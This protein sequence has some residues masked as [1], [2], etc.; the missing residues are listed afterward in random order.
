MK[1]VCW[2]LL[3]LWTPGVWAQTP[4]KVGSKRF[5][6][7]Y[8]LGEILKQTAL[9]AAEAQV[10][11]RQGLG[12]T[13]IL[14]AALKSGSIDIYPEYTGTIDQ[15]LLRNQTP[16]DLARLQRQLAPLGLGVAVPLGFNN[17]YALA[18]T[19][20]RA[21]QLGI[22][23]LSDLARHPAVKLGLSQEFLK[24]Q[25]GWPGVKARYKL[26][27]APP[28][29]LDHGLAYEAIAN[30]QV[31]VIDIYST[32]AKIARYRLRV[33]EDDRK[34]FPAYEAVLFYR[35]DLPQRLPRTWAA[36]Q[37]LKGK[38]PTERMIALNA[39]AE[40]ENQ[41]FSAIAASFLHASTEPASQ[42]NF[43]S[44]L[45]GPDFWRLTG[46]HVLL[47]FVSLTAGVLMGV[48][49]GIWAARVPLVAPVVLGGVGVI[50]TIP[51]LA[52][53][54]FLIPFL[55]QI[56]TFPALVALFLYALLPIVRNTYTGL[57][58]IAPGLRESAQAL[59]LPE[60]AR[61]RLIELPLAARSI[62]AG[63]KTSAVINVGTAT[64][65]AFIGAGGFGERIAQGLALNDNNTLLSGAIPA[66]LLA[67]LVQVGF[68]LLDRW[69][70][71]AGLQQ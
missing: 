6:E 2:L 38:I 54:A 24:R 71:P 53:L 8:I 16:S 62:L 59:G 17:T 68:E 37:E 69:L 43:L 22:R 20:E 28:Q 18:M 33:L 64:I 65:A 36:L 41:S 39:Q 44:L 31:E 47:V 1:W 15:E 42:E 21:Q 45:L 46:E 50:Q 60:L 35:L 58:D 13:G 48:P 61:L 52:L 40:L 70:I 19:E 3:I 25:D 63:I 12:N 51:S 32:D 66:A 55:R 49:L 11:H 9:K 34:F 10:N 67:I 14:F 26:P 57:T 5:T 7:S 27:F 30:G 29:G 23:T 4:L 56:G